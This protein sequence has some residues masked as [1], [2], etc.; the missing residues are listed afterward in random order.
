M[1][2]EKKVKIEAR[3]IAQAEEEEQKEEQERADFFTTLE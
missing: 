3:R 1:D 2:Y